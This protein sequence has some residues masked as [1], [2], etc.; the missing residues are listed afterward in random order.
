[1]LQRQALMLERMARGDALFSKDGSSH[2]YENNDD[3]GG[4]EWDSALSSMRVDWRTQFSKLFEAGNEEA[5]ETFRRCLGGTSSSSSGYDPTFSVNVRPVRRDEWA[6]AESAWINQVEKRL[7][8]VTLRCLRERE[9]LHLAAFLAATEAVVMFCCEKREAPPGALVPPALSTYLAEPLRLEMVTVPVRSRN[10]MNSSSSSSSSKKK[11][12]NSGSGRSRQRVRTQ[13]FSAA[14]RPDGEEQI[15]VEK[16][17]EGEQEHE[18]IVNIA[19][20][21]DSNSSSSSCSSKSK[22]KEVQC[23]RLAVPDSLRRLTLHALCQF[24]SLK[25]RSSSSD[26]SDAAKITY[27]TIPDASSSS[28]KKQHMLAGKVSLSGFLTVCS[29][30]GV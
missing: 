22:S 21:G 18:T 30:E 20:T 8:T 5:A 12:S 9:D 26:G 24:Y 13:P 10:S 7:R 16:K 14:A 25:C 29:G 28:S 11:T 1:M 3:E 17:R 2:N 27:I 6:L 23:L 15:E 4:D 19:S